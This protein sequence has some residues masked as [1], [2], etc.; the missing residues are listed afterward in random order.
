MT[1]D[2]RKSVGNKKST[3]SWAFL[4]KVRKLLSLFGRGSNNL[5]IDNSK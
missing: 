4:P 1:K 2:G 5:I 3:S